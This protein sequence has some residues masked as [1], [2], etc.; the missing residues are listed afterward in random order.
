MGVRLDRVAFGIAAILAVLAIAAVWTSLVRTLRDPAPVASTLTARSL[1]WSGRV[2]SDKQQ[3]DAW[4]RSR[5]TRYE[6]WARTHPSAAAVFDPGAIEESAA[7]TSKR[8]AA[9]DRP[10]SKTKT[11]TKTKTADRS[12]APARAESSASG[13]SPWPVGLAAFATLLALLTI[14]T[15]L[16][17]RN[18][19]PA[20]LVPHAS[21]IAEHR[22]QLIAAA[23]TLA[24]GILVGVGLS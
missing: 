12:A 11:K 17:I 22:A 9:A 3:L 8:T 14:A 15:P 6:T 18:V 2:F 23:L 19:V 24:F 21:V 13:H 4:L 16:L 5:G 10:E 20:R 1:V 7:R